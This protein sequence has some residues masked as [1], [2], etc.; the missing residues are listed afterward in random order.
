MSSATAPRC[1][2]L[3][4]FEGERG[5]YPKGFHH[6][7]LERRNTWFCGY[8]LGLLDKQRVRAETGAA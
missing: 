1:A 6:R 7:P 5:G 3:G 2:F 8:N 4:K